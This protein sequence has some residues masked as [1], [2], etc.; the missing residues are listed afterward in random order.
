MIGMSI[1]CISVLNMCHVLKPFVK[2][3]RIYFF[4]L[5]LVLSENIYQVS[6]SSSVAMKEGMD[7]WMS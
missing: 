4:G 1:K 3:T 5:M 7:G 2:S 6:G